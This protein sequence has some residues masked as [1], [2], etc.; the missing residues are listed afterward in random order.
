MARRKSCV[1]AAPSSS[2]SSRQP[3]NSART[4]STA[5]VTHAAIG[6]ERPGP[7]P[8]STM[9]TVNTTR[10][11]GSRPSA[12][13]RVRLCQTEGVRTRGGR[14][15]GRV[16]SPPPDPAR[17]GIR[18]DCGVDDDDHRHTGPR[19]EDGAGFA[20]RGHHLYPGQVAPGDFVG[21][22]QPDSVVAAEFVADSDHQMCQRRS[23]VKVRKCVEQEMHGS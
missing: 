7:R 23:I 2:T 18:T 15:G 17:G 4:A 16:G 6:A 1:R 11:S 19:V 10:R 8:V 13:R 14:I 21:H 9:S 5:S 22:R 12:Q 20:D 3:A